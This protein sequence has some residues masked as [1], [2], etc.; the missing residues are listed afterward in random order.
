MEKQRYKW[1]CLDLIMPQ[2]HPK[3]YIKLLILDYPYKMILGN[4]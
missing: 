3:G 4:S 1:H 2:Q